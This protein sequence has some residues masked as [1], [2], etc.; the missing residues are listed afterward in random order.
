MQISSV[1]AWLKDVAEPFLAS[2]GNMGSDLASA[3]EF[4]NRHQHFAT[5]VINKEHEVHTILNRAHELPEEDR[6]GLR[7]FQQRYENLKQALE[8][9]IQLGNT[10]QQV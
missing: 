7:D 10:Y 3:N 1:N 6:H 9:R 5:E 8:W 4:V 2:S